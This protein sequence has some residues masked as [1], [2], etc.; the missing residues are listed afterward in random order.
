MRSFVEKIKVMDEGVETSGGR[1]GID[2]PQI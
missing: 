2:K 1:R